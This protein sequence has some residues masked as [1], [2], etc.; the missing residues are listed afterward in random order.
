MGLG[1]RPWRRGQDDAAK[2]AGNVQRVPRKAARG[3][4]DFAAADQI[5]SGQPKRA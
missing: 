1:R 4:E 3:W 2:V 5:E